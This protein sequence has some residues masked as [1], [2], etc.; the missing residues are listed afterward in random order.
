M[1]KA[2]RTARLVDA[3]VVITLIA[4]MLGGAVFFS[5]GFTV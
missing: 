5:Q 2:I 1:D 4:G 3:V